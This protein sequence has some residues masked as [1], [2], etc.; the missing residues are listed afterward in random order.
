MGKIL[1]KESAIIA[2]SPGGVV[3][4]SIKTMKTEMFSEA[5]ESMQY[6]T[7]NISNILLFL[8]E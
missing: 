1:F 6:V 2:Y 4:G 5:I 7:Y 8:L 3:E